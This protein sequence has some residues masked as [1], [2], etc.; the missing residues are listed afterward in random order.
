[1]VL[2][3]INYFYASGDSF[4]FG[5][6]MGESFQRNLY[7]FTFHHRKHCY[8]GIMC[9]SLK[10]V[11]RYRNKALPGGSNERVYRK[12]ICNLSEDLLKFKPENMFVT[13][14][15]THAHRREFYM[16]SSKN[17][18]PHMYAY[19][20]KKEDEVV[21]NLWEMLVQ[22]VSDDKGINMFDVMQILG[23]QNFLIKNKIPYLL[24]TS[25]GTPEENA[26][27][28]KSVPKQVLNQIYKPRFYNELS[29]S[30]FTSINGYSRGPGWHP[31]E[32]AHRAWANHLLE[33]I[34]QNDLFSNEDLL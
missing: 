31:L 16:N 17:W 30:S 19:S 34:N 10:S 14:S 11:L 6:E 7:D 24:T 25:M 27:L 23:I 2:S 4:A 5:Q 32:D 15:L 8:T 22:E 28:E 18:Y 21:Y 26:L 33:H 20:P 12:L 13:I 9:D 1:M 29:F 3:M